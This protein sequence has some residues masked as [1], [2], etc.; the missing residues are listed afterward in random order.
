MAR[1]RREVRLMSFV[2]CVALTGVGLFASWL[3][4]RRKG[5]RSGVRLAAW[6]LLPIAAWLTGVATLIERL[7][8]AFTRFGASFVFSTKTWAGLLVAVAAVL[9]FLVSG[10]IP[11]VSKR[12]A[13]K[14]AKDGP[15]APGSAKPAPGTA[16]TAGKTGRS[17]KA[18]PAADDDGLGD[19][20]EI[21]RRRGIS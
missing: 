1:P 6:S 2:I 4:W 21:L 8:S 19:V 3:R 18:R 14:A 12:R 20:E 11:A 9:L 17:A 7:G 16:I 13:R 10:G 15:G 5:P